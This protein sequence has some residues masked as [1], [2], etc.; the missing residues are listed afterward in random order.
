MTTYRL[1]IILIALNLLVAG[2]AKGQK[3]VTKT[4]LMKVYMHYMTWF[5]TPATIGTWGWHWKMNTKNPDI[6]DDN[7]HRQIASHYYPLIG[8]YASR[9]KDVIE[10]HLLLMKLSGVDGILI[11][12]YGVQ[13]SNSD[14]QD[15]LTSSNSIISYTDDFG[16]QFGVVLEDR[17][18]R[19]VDDVKANFA[20]LKDNYFT[21]SEY[22]R[23]G[24]DHAPLVCIFGPVTFT[25]PTNWDEILP[26][27]GEDVEFIPM[28]YNSGLA[29]SNSDGEFMWVYQ[30]NQNHLT[31]LTNFYN[32][33][34]A[35]LKT[36]MGVAYPGFEDFYV[37]GGAG[38]SYFTILP[39][40]GATLDATLNLAEQNKSKIDM[41]QLVTFNDFGEG[42]MFEPTVETGFSYLM[43]IQKY[44]GVSYGE[45][46]LRLVYRLYNLRKKYAS[47]GSVQSQLDKASYDLRN[48]KIDSAAVIINALDPSS[49][50]ADKTK[51]CQNIAIYPNPYTGGNIVIALGDNLQGRTS[52]TIY[53]SL[54]RQVYNHISEIENQEITIP[55]PN[56]VPGIYTLI[57]K[58]G[59]TVRTGKFVIINE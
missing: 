52:L 35:G 28:W 5:E 13:G 8:P 43:K 54:G 7:G 40:D 31:H 34:A 10:Y 24:S 50:I 15:L 53:S 3:P 39:D 22:I 30:D 59:T 41:V 29:G 49:K 18:S 42:T 19:S 32:N 11:D 36:V 1:K 55:D 23:Y 21:N 27:A 6:I 38:D 20:Y 16:M 26:S 2:F 25:S 45:N 33:R 37:E 9:D 44:T 58:N 57:I 56:L 4:N 51:F 46:E 14:I 17:F 47:D 12:W 48:L